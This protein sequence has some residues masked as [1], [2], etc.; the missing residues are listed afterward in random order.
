MENIFIL[1]LAIA[2]DLV[3]GE[4][5]ARLHPVMWMGGVISLLLKRAP[6]RDAARFLYGAFMVC[7]CLAL[8]SLPAYFLLLYIK[9]FSTP[10]YVIAVAVLLKATFSLKGLFQAARKVKRFLDGGETAKARQEVSYLVSRDTRK[11]DKPHIISAVVEMSAESVTDSIVAPLFYWLL[12]GVP[13]AI[14]YRV[15]NTLDSRIGYHGEYEYLGKFA[16]RLDDVLNFIPARISGLLLVVSAYLCRMDGGRAWSIMLRD[17]SRTES[18]NAGWTMSAVAGALGVRLEKPGCYRLGDAARPLA[19]S[20]ITS[21]L[22]LVMASS[23]FW[24]GICISATGT[25]YAVTA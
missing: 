8:F 5:P 11:L 4:Y 25:Y 22:R 20:S 7:F 18:P 9:G 10:A 19:P 16:A 14:A 24:C 3:I 1:P 13:G 21:G 15:V 17:R 12:L 6:R 2:I 23:V